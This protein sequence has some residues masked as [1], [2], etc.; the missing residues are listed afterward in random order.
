MKYQDLRKRRRI[1]IS[2][3]RNNANVSMMKKNQRTNN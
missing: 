3:N 1:N 2:S